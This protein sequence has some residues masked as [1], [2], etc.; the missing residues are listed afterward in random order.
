MSGGYFFSLQYRIEEIADSI[1]ELV[2]N[3]DSTEKNKWGG[4]VGRHY[5]PAIIERFK[6]TAQC[7]RRGAAMVKRVDWLVSGDDG[8]ESFLKQWDFDE[9]LNRQHSAH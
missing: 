2:F 5:Q 8:E 3:N 7:L 6:E 9:G 1:D 4:E